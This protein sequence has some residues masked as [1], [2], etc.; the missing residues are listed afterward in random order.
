MQAD[1]ERAN[2]P[3]QP[4]VAESQRAR[5]RN[6]TH[7]SLVDGGWVASFGDRQASRDRLGPQTISS[8]AELV[9]PSSSAASPQASLRPTVSS[10]GEHPLR[11]GSIFSES[12][13]RT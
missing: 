5:D 9:Q 7:S 11:R 6:H 12:S 8:P 1:I 2:L 10:W 3:R 13:Q 4:P